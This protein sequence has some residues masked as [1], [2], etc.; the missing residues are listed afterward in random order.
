MTNSL[1]IVLTKITVNILYHGTESVSFLSPKILS[2][3]P[4][5]LKKINSC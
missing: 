4:D 5:R 3:L 2:I 1:L